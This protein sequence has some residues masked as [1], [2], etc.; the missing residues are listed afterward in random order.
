MR[1]TVSKL[2]QAAAGV[3]F[4]IFALCA[5]NQNMLRLVREVFA[6]GRGAG[7]ATALKQWLSKRRSAG[8]EDGNEI[9][10]GAFRT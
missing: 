9:A 7:L 3:I 10:D 6:G 1:P 5:G 8:R 2:P 4:A